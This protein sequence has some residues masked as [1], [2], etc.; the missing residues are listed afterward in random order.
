MR[1]RSESLGTGLMHESRRSQRCYRR[2]S[3]VSPASSTAIVLQ[4]AALSDLSRHHSVA[5]RAL[6]RLGRGANQIP[7]PDRE[8][9]AFDELLDRAR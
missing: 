7:L 1:S 2:V 8:V 5:M 4:E 6:T 9:F 3:R